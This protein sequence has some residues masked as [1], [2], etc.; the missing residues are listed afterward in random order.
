MIITDKKYANQC[1]PPAEKMSGLS[2]V[3]GEKASARVIRMGMVTSAV[4]R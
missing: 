3:C 1:L 2:Q 4:I